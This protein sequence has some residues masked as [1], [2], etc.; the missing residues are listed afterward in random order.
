VKNSY[1]LSKISRNFPVSSSNEAKLF[2]AYLKKKDDIEL[3]EE[4]LQKV[5]KSTGLDQEN[6]LKLI[7]DK[8]SIIQVPVSIFNNDLAPLEAVALFLKENLGYTLHKIASLLNRDD[9]TI[10][11][12]YDNASKKNVKLNLKSEVYIPLS[13]FSD[14]KLSILENLASYLIEIRKFSVKQISALTGKHQKTVWTVY[15]RAQKKKHAK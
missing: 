6:I 10:W 1:K 9:R 8:D 7:K 14:R 2:D 4:V 13:I 11:L 5:R 12:T 15:S 3:L